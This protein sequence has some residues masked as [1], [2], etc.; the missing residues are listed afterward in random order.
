MGIEKG[1]KLRCWLAEEKR[2]I[3]LH[4]AAPDVSIAQVARRYAMNANLIHKWLKDPRF[5]PA[6]PEADG[7]LSDCDFL[8]IEISDAERKEGT[9]VVPD[10]GPDRSDVFA[11]RVDIT[12]S[13]GRRVLIE[14]PTGL[15]SVV[16]LVQGLRS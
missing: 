3:C 13:D 11:R 1:R 14:G 10:H 2:T 6:T 5:A 15:S 8:P 7:A 12:L 9:M 16:G 4:T